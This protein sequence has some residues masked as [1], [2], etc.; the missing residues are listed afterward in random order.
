MTDRAGGVTTK[1]V[2][3]I[4]DDGHL[5]PEES[6]HD[7]LLASLGKGQK[8]DVLHRVGVNYHVVAVFGG[9]SSGKSTLLNC[10]FRTQFET[11]NETQRRGQT[12]KGA[13]IAR[14][15]IE[16]LQAEDE[17]PAEAAAAA[18]AEEAPEAAEKEVEPM[19][20]A[21][22]PLFVVDFEGTDGIEHGEDQSFERK[23]SLFALSVADTLIINMWS[24]DVGRFN[25]AN[26]SLLRTIFEVNL[27]LF[28]HDSYVKEEK[29]T[30]LVVLRD[31]TEDDT[32]HYFETVRKSFDKIWS[33]IVKPEA[34]KESSIDALFE[35]RY[36]VL[37][38]YKLQRA[39]FDKAATAFRDWFV[40]PKCD[41]FLFRHMGMFRGVPL[42]GVPKYMSSCW[43]VISKSKDLDIPTQREMLARHRCIDAR[44]AA[45]DA[46]METCREYGERLQQGELVP[47]LSAVL[48]RAMDDRL[49]DF[50]SQTRLYTVSVVQETSVQ[51]EEELLAAELKLLWQYA[52]TIAT[53]VLEEM[54]TTIA[55]AVD[56]T[57][58]WLLQEAQSLP[59]VS[60][61]K[62][63]GGKDEFGDSSKGS[64]ETRRNNA[65]LA[66]NEKCNALVQRF[67][68]RLCHTLQTNTEVLYQHHHQQQ[69]QQPPTRLYARFAAFVANDVAMKEAVAH[70]V[71]D[72]VQQKVCHRF[73]SMAENASETIHQAFEQS[74]TR[75]PDGTVRFFNTTKG[76]Q[77]AEPQSRQA[78]L[79]LLGCLLYYRL[80]LVI[81]EEKGNETIS[82]DDSGRATA[83]LLCERRRLHVRD[84]SAEQKFFLFYSRISDPPLYPT[85][86][87]VVTADSGVVSDGVADGSCV[88]LSQQAVQRAFD[89]YTQKC[90]FTMQLQLRTI[91]SGK[92]R[93]PAWVLPVML[94]LG[95]NELYYVL[96]S[97]LLLMI[98]IAVV[99]VFFRHVILSQWEV[100]E[101]TGPAW[102]VVAVRTVVQQLRG[103]Y[104]TMMPPELNNRDGASVRHRDPTDMNDVTPTMTTSADSAPEM[105]HSSLTRRVNKEQTSGGY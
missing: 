69:S 65:V 82:S 21:S 35:L 14:A 15:A 27:Q 67:W 66:D 103:A 78:G 96:T 64:S 88:L 56:G 57:V 41:N 104:E 72:A 10:L 89:L 40:A 19:A 91:E 63:C 92:Q 59:L 34:F 23:L 58:R 49:R 80:K 55:G 16:T 83:K 36:H 3:L 18:V 29:P 4:G 28:S 77:G 84:N 8:S 98:L 105:P 47:Q 2:H 9:Q 22:P 17:R 30:L 94:L 1:G 43:E 54:D 101:E 102:L 79:V 74:L 95:W 31:F 97:P 53:S 81:G 25:A 68:A 86:V 7:F 50:H 45:E 51:L 99:M 44:K 6:I 87:P 70:A 39:A 48:E 61:Q 5:L 73:S 26:M 38:H 12:T 13:F 46:F 100:F 42:D 20:G 37:P 32:T 33:S 93:L 75:R 60:A 85:G 76:L 71:M 24:V 52:R 11:L 90:E 62:G